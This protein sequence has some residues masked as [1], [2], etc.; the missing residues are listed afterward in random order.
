MIPLLLP[1][2][3]TWHCGNNQFKIR[4]MKCEVRK[5]PQHSGRKNGFW[6]NLQLHEMMWERDQIL[7][8]TSGLWKKLFAK[9]FFWLSK[10]SIK[11]SIKSIKIYWGVPQGSHLASSVFIWYISVPTHFHWQNFKTSKHEIFFLQSVNTEFS[12]LKNVM[13]ANYLQVQ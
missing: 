11:S 13:F 9:N 7:S 10:V 1:Q 12:Y 4:K 6:C 8:Q 2:C 3:C 5:P